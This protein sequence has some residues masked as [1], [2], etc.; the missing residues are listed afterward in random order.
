[1]NQKNVFGYIELLLI[2][3]YYAKNDHKMISPDQWTNDSRKRLTIYDDDLVFGEKLVDQNRK[4]RKVLAFKVRCFCDVDES[5]NA[6]I[7]PTR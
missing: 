7:I 4:K 6:F 3:Y 2:K 1:V 5:E